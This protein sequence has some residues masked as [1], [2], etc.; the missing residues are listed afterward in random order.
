MNWI[1][2]IQYLLIAQKILHYTLIHSTKCTKKVLTRNVRS[3]NTFSMSQHTQKC[4][5]RFIFIIIT[6][7][8]PVY[9]ST[10]IQSVH[11]KRFIDGDMLFAID[12]GIITFSQSRIWGHSNTPTCLF[13]RCY[14]AAARQAKTVCQYPQL[15][16]IP[17]KLDVEV[18]NIH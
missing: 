11:T 15:I 4:C 7:I 3:V 13:T 16:V 8:R 14:V 5:Y 9:Y 2:V 6:I 1:V 17:K 18:F 10:R 12:N